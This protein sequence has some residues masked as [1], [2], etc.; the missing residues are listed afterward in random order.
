MPTGLQIISAMRKNRL[1]SIPASAYQEPIVSGKTAFR[2][3]HLVMAPEAVRRV[4]QDK[5]ENYVL[6]ELSHHLLR[7]FKKSIFLVSGS[8]WRRHRKAV[9]QS[10]TPHA[11][12]PTKPHIIAAADRLVSRLEQ[13][14]TSVDVYP[15]IRSATF[16]VISRLVTGP[17]YSYDADEVLDALDAYLDKVTPIS[18]L[19][20]VRI[21]RWLPLPR[22]LKAWR[23]VRFLHR[24]AQKEIRA[25]KQD[26]CPSQFIDR[27]S[28]AVDPDTGERLSA[29]EIRDNVLVSL[30][31]GHDTVTSTISWMLFLLAQHADLQET[32]RAEVLSVVG[33]NGEG[34]SAAPGRLPLCRRII[35]E[36]MRLY[37]PAPILTRQAVQDDEILG[38]PIKRGDVVV[39]PLCAINRHHANWD[40]PHLFKP[41]RFVSRPDRYRFMPFSGGQRFCAGA[42]MAY[43]EMEILLAVLLANYRFHPTEQV[44]EACA[45]LLLRPKGGVHLRLERLAPQCSR[46]QQPVS[47]AP[48]TNAPTQATLQDQ[49]S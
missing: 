18:V 36:T 26:R 43:L 12:G 10:L 35:D 15:E 46:K 47:T 32:A 13:Q 33:Q 42:A 45:D 31:A 49:S 34:L 17:N 22:Y 20:Y 19:N 28:S 29:T 8:V 4:L 2:Q 9:S 25:N 16:E 11:L 24:I 14:G 5:S 40:D 6:P 37:P 21:P 44:P 27:L 30:L 48:D 23:Q 3:L 1:L 39:V 38:T 41:E 7:V